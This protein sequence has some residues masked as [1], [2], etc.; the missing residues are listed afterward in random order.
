MAVLYGKLIF[1]ENAVQDLRRPFRVGDGEA[2]I[3]F[4][5]GLQVRKALLLQQHTV[6]DD[7]DVVRQQG[8]L[9]EDV[10][11]DQDGLAPFV[12]QRPDEGA[13][14]RDADGVQAVDG[15]VQNQQLRVVHHS[16]GNGQTLFHAQGVLGKELLIPIRQAHQLQGAFDGALIFQPPQSGEDTEILRCGQIGIK[17]GGLDQTAD[18]GQQFLLVTHQRLPPD[19]H[20]PGSGLGQ[21]QQHFHSGGLSG[22]VPA[23][24]TVDAAPLN[25]DVQLRYALLCPVLFGQLFRFND[26]FA[27]SDYLLCGVSIQHHP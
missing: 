24:Q 20:V 21:A 11:G 12:T 9:G 25:M 17:A 13:H 3:P 4:A 23:Q 6:V 22:S 15:L 27:H 2:D 14:L 18:A 7:A 5:L 26:Y 1:V 16:Q 19:G 10:A 8:H